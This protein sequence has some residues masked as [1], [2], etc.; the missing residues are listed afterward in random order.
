[1]KETLKCLIKAFI[2]ES[3]A[4]NRYTYYAKV[5]K[6]EGYEQIAEIFNITSDQESVHAKRLFEHIQEL[7][8]E[9]PEDEQAE[10]PIDASCPTTFGDTLTNLKAARDGEHYENTTMYPDFA[11]IAKKEGYG[12]IAARF[13]GISKAEVHHEK[14]YIK[15]IEQL[16]NKT[17]FEKSEKVWW[18]CRVCGY[19]VFSTKPP[20]K[21]PA[22]NHSKAYY[23]TQCEEY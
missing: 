15:L 1:M 6:K 17:L 22:C 23:Q 10:I 13:L 16:E 12:K 3:Q 8:K 11:K 18:I 9:L 2:G 20:E 4:R 19:A 5:A 7:K 21:C 14:R